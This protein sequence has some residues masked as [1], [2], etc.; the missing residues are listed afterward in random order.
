MNRTHDRLSPEERRN[1]C[2]GCAAVSDA[3]GN[4][5][6]AETAAGHVETGMTRHRSIDRGNLLE[7]ADFVLRVRLLPSKNAGERGL[8]ADAEERLQ[9]AHRQID[10]LAIA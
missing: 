10:E 2:G 1:L 3:I 4:T 8:A 9:R 5:R 6:A 7:M